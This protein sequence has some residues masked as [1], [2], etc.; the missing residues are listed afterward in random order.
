LD[1][2]IV[3]LDFFDAS[4]NRIAAYVI[5]IRSTRKAMLYALLDPTSRLRELEAR[6]NR[7]SN[8]ALM[9]EMKTLPFGDV[10]DE[11]CRRA[12]VPVGRAWIDECE[13]YEQEVLS[14][15]S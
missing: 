10:W 15:R 13:G 2:A 4:I 5:G 8:L 7:G 11:L 9:E 6:G 12:D 1:R 3:A 14:N